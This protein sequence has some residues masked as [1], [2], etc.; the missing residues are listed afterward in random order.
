IEI[1]LTRCPGDLCIVGHSGS[2]QIPDNDTRH[3]RLRCTQPMP[4]PTARLLPRPCRGSSGRGAEHRCTV[5]PLTLTL[6]LT[7]NLPPRHPARRR[8]LTSLFGGACSLLPP[9][10]GLGEENDQG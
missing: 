4:E 3:A 1:R 7:P 5:L 9:P 2:S 8:G 10:R 6:V